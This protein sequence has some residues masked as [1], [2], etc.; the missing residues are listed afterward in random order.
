MVL[1]LVK[2][3]LMDSAGFIETPQEEQ[4]ENNSAVHVQ[5]IRG[6]AIQVEGLGCRD[7]GLKENK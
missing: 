1:D 4:G 2:P 5:A 6:D 3:S 7:V